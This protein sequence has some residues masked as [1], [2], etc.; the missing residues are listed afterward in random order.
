MG[1]PGGMA[2]MLC[3][4]QP[5]TC[6]A[7]LPKVVTENTSHYSADVVELPYGDSTPSAINEMRT[8]AAKA[9]YTKRITTTI[10]PVLQSGGG[11]LSDDEYATLSAIRT[12]SQAFE[13]EGPDLEPYKAHLEQP[14]GIPERAAVW[15]TRR[16][17]KGQGD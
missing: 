6:N 5:C 1:K 16:R 14:P 7:K 13:L 15:R 8:A 17:T 12:L 10:A 2:C 11:R 9:R 4:G 3:G